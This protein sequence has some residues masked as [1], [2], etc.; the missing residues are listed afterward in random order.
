[1]QME[2]GQTGHHGLNAQRHV[3]MEHKL[4][5]EPAPTPVPSTMVRIVQGNA[6]K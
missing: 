4:T 5:T 3:E 6:M 2:T 1:M